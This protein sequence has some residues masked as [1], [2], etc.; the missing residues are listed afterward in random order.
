MYTAPLFQPQSIQ[1]VEDF[2]KEHG[3]AI[4]IS[5][6]NGIPI[7]THIPLLLTTKPSGERVFTGHF[8]KANPQWKN[9][10]EQTQVLAIFAGAHAYISSS[11]YDHVNV[12]TW[13]YTAVH[14]Y[15]KFRIITDE[16]LLDSLKALT[17]KYEAAS[18]N[19]VRVE[20]MPENYVRREMRGV[21]G[22]EMTIDSIQATF[23][24]SQNR[25]DANHDS[26][27]QHLHERNEG[28]DVKIATAM[29][30]NRP[31]N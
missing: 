4:V 24:L 28:D 8:A 31:K 30:C 11:W 16:A 23:K 3:F 17:D 19:P 13:N 1:Q 5:Q 10:V 26:I 29:Q 6:Q 27:I 14:I 21:V 12:S 18:K 2:L 20:T 7:A 15:G 25:D 22:F 9:I